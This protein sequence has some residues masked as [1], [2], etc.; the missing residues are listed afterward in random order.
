MDQELRLNTLSVRKT[1]KLWVLFWAVMSLR[2]RGGG[3]RLGV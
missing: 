3:S 1:Q 2:E